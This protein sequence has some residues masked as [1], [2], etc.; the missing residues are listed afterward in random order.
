MEKTYGTY[1]DYLV[2]K[3]LEGGKMAFSIREIAEKICQYGT[4]RER[5]NFYY[6][7]RR[8]IQNLE[9]AGYLQ[10]QT[11]RLDGNNLLINKYKIKDEKR[12][13]LFS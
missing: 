3:E 10:K 11:N 4:R 7:V 1:L 9:N 2:L 13:R 6:R 5:T 12:Q 8:S